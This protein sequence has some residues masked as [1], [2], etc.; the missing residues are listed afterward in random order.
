ML[1]L[2]LNSI[3][4]ELLFEPVNFNSLL[5]NSLNKYHPAILF[6]TLLA[7]FTLLTSINSSKFWFSKINSTNFLSI[8]LLVSI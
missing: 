8:I 6:T 7:S 1:L 4:N 5:V 3:Y 2:N